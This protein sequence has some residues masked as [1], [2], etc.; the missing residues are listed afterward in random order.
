MLFMADRSFPCGDILRM[1]LPE[2]CEVCASIDCGIT[3]IRGALGPDMVWRSFTTKR[4]CHL[5]DFADLLR[6]R[7]LTFRAGPFLRSM[8]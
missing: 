8:G 1:D 4:E 5:D 7:G 3:M 6:S 2:F